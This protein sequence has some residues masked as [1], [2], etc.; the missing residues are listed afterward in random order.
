MF[1]RTRTGMHPTPFAQSLKGAVS[2]VVEVV[3]TEIFCER[4][5]DPATSTRHFIFST[6]DIGELVFLPLLLRAA[7]ESAPGVTFQ[8]VVKP[9]RE[10][11]MALATGAVDLALGY[12][13]D[14]GGAGFYEQRLFD[15][16]F[17]SVVRRDHPEVGAQLT[18]KQ[19]LALDHI[20]VEQEGRSQ[21]IF[22]KRM[23][24]LGL[25]RRV[26]LRSPHFMSVPLLIAKS[27]M[28]TTVPYAVGHAYAG[29]GGCRLLEP[30][31]DIPRILLKQC[32]HDRVHQDAGAVWLR[33]LISRLFLNH[34]PTLSD[35]LEIDNEAH[36]RRALSS[37]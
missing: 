9:P 1:V 14:L 28:V 15:H 19:F 25:Q 4:G 36:R 7:A 13:P 6:S 27:D 2:K 12:F 10:L 5:F 34:D 8:C 33:Q 18:L 26:V 22:E 32:W 31:I 35:P 29:L 23:A 16:S 20:V 30:P 17:T 21:E 3:R 11:G 24:E 37:E